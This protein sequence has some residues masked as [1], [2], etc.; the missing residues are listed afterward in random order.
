MSLLLAALIVVLLFAASFGGRRIWVA[1]ASSTLSF[2]T[3]AGVAFIANA[4]SAGPYFRALA[5]EL[6]PLLRTSAEDLALAAESTATSFASLKFRTATSTQTSGNETLTP[7]PAGTTASAEEQ[8]T[9]PD[10]SWADPSA[11]LA[12]IEWPDPRTWFGES[13]SAPEVDLQIGETSQPSKDASAA[14]S[15]ED[16]LPKVRAMMPGQSQK[17]PT[18]E[19]PAQAA[20]NPTYRIVRAPPQTSAPVSAAPPQ[21]AGAPVKWLSQSLAPPG[22]TAVVLT[23]TNISDAPLED[24]QA[25]LKPDPEKIPPGMANLVLRLSIQESDGTVTPA[26]SIPP[27]A[28]FHLQAEDLSEADAA[29]LSGAIVSFGYSQEGR[30]RTSIMYLSETASAGGTP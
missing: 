27:G 28:R 29:R 2:L 30:R 17:E 3:V 20:A 10:L 21:D 23:G 14:R 22:L 24:I 15:P 5:G 26:G 19:A 25:R 9:W 7:P 4:T 12:S 13:E 1:L 6:P 8:T 11:W 16:P 18:Q